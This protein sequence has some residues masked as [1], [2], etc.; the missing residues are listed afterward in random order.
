MLMRNLNGIFLITRLKP[1][2]SSVD[3]RFGNPAEGEA[4]V[5]VVLVLSVLL[6]F[7]LFESSRS[8]DTQG[9]RAPCSAMP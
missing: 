9:K 6:Y 4:I 1:L 3:A 5:F 2:A 7:A 8:Q